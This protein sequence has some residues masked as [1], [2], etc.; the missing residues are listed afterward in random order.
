MTVRKHALILATMGITTM[1]LTTPVSANS[2]NH[3]SNTNV[4][5]HLVV[6]HRSYGIKES[7]TVSKQ[8]TDRTWSGA[9]IKVGKIR[10]LKLAHRYTINN[11]KEKI[12]A[13]GLVMIHYTITAGKH[14]LDVDPSNCTYVFNNGEE[15]EGIDNDHAFANGIRAGKTVSG[16]VAVPIESTHHFAKV[17]AEFNAHYYTNNDNDK[18][19]DHTYIMALQY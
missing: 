10:L 13:H 5:T 16:W 6:N 1:L 7:H 3:Q 4:K 11:G 2:A 15:H 12:K 9:S 14:D 18:D 8:H 17:T 19:Q